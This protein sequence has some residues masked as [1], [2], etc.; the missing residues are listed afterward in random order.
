MKVHREQAASGIMEMGCSERS[1]VKSSQS[2]LN[3]NRFQDVA[4]GHICFDY[5]RR[6]RRIH[7][8]ENGRN[9]RRRR[10]ELCLGDHALAADVN[11]SGQSCLQP[12]R[13]VARSPEDQLSRG[14][15]EGERNY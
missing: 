12:E 9:C 1:P 14:P 5:R 4:A 15:S 6:C 10:E 3:L 13:K 8:G 7:T 11:A 2:T